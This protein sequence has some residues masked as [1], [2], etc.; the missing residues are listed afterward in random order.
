MALE[1]L[2]CASLNTGLHGSV[3]VMVDLHGS[4]ANMENLLRIHSGPTN[5]LK[6]TVHSSFVAF[7][8]LRNF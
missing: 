1:G 2:G 7:S 5:R 6:E 3:V 8:L 4:S